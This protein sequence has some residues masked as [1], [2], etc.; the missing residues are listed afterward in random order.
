MPLDLR[1]GVSSKAGGHCFGRLWIQLL[2]SRGYAHRLLTPL[3]ASCHWQLPR[4]LCVLPPILVNAGSKVTEV[5]VFG[6]QIPPVA[7]M[8]T[9]AASRPLISQAVHVA[10]TVTTASNTYDVAI[11]DFLGTLL[12]LPSCQSAASG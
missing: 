9:T 5:S 11:I 2:V 4:E 6:D 3:S 12:H 8:N 7:Y 10:V 1:S